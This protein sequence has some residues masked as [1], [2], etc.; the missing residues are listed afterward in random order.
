VTVFN[1]LSWPRKALVD[2]AG[3]KAEVIVPACG[4]TTVN[5]PSSADGASVCAG[6]LADGGAVLENELLR[7]E[8]NA[9][10]EIVHLIDKASG[11]D[12][13]S[14]AGNRFRLY[15]DVPGNWDAWDLDSMAEDMPVEL[16]GG[17]KLEVI[18]TGPFA[19]SLRLTRSIHDSSLT[20]TISL[21]RGSK[22]IDFASGVDWKESH[23]LLKVNFPTNIYATEAVHEVQF[24]HLRR[25]NHASRK[26]DADRFEVCNQKWSALAEETRGVAVLNDCKYG[27]SVKGNS[28]NLSLLKSA[29]A[30]DMVADKGIQ[31]FTYALYFWNG[32][33][34][35]SGV[36]QEAYDLNAPV[37][38]VAG[39][40]GEASLFQ[41]DAAN[42]VIETVKPAVDG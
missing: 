7:A 29:L 22:R 21:R 27:L 19:A 20:Q 40:G 38:C 26:F 30:P 2:V 8:F 17:A 14:G 4:W 41:L 23:K 36:L 37:T 11:R 31:T 25:P 33:L 24:G 10:G 35:D 15:K 6:M 3:G 5:G 34:A 39:D 16:C 9:L 28:I 13:L 18:A 1:S 32:S 12:Q 42:I